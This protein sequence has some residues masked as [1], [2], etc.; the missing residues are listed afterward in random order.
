MFSRSVRSA[1]DQISYSR[2][3]CWIVFFAHLG[4]SDVR[5]VGWLG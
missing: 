2:P 1:L 4:G 3:L 5:D